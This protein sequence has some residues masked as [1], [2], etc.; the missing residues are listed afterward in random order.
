MRR[1]NMLIVALGL[2]PI[3][4]LMMMPSLA[5]AN[6]V[7][8]ALKLLLE[9]ALWSGSL[10]L[11]NFP[12]HRDG[13]APV[14]TAVESRSIPIEWAGVENHEYYD[15]RERI[16]SR[17][18]FEWQETCFI[19]YRAE[20]I[21]E[22]NEIMK[23]HV[24]N[25][26]ASAE[27][28]SGQMAP[29]ALDDLLSKVLVDETI[30]GKIF[31]LTNYYT[32]TRY[33]QQTYVRA[34]R[35]AVDLNQARVSDDLLESDAYLVGNIAIEALRSSSNGQVTAV[36]IAQH[37][38]NALGVG[39]HLG[40][41]QPEWLVVYAGVSPF[42]LHGRTIEEWHLVSV[43]PQEWVFESPRDPKGKVANQNSENSQNEAGTSSLR[44][45]YIRFHLDRRYQDAL[46]RLEIRYSDGTVHTWRTL[47][48]RWV[49]GTWWPS[50][51]EVIEKSSSSEAQS[52]MIL[53]R[54][55]RTQS[56]I[57]LQIPEK[58]P[59]FDY[60]RFGKDAWEGKLNYERTEWS[61]ALLQAIRQ[62]D[63][64]PTASP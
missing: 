1:W 56:P 57:D 63:K 37:E 64:K 51:V 41:M 48:Y 9:F 27:A 60:R 32:I 25:L 20:W 54:A 26:F 31:E 53:V 29:Q 2:L 14:S 23:N 49:E 61:E 50:E 8:P 7:R 10:P 47:K 11:H 43:S 35:Q 22:Q 24:L 33:S 12:P 15:N 3:T 42:R 55:Q 59:V 28:E 16:A 38:A 13:I 19:S 34:Q 45:P 5:V 62:S 17:M 36:H 40:G 6:D 18:T 52:R 21:R 44:Y 58:T 30:G 39:T 4:G 46:S